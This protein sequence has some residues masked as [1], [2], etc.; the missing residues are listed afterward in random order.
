M[1]IKNIIRELR[2]YSDPE[3]V[4]V[5]KYYTPAL[6]GD[7]GVRSLDMRALI[8]IGGV[9]LMV[10]EKVVYDRYDIIVK[11]F[12]W[13]VRELSKSDKP[14]VEMFMERFEGRLAGSVKREEATKQGTGLKNG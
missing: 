5:S 7:L 14:E 10:C 13:F 4:E 6:K 8:S 3:R 12:S 1:Q 11:A 9:T 2:S